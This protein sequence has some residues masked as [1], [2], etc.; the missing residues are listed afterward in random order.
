MIGSAIAKAAKKDVGDSIELNGVRFRIVGVYES[1]VGWEEMGGVISLRDAQTITGRPRKVTMISVKVKDPAQAPAIVD[2]I[3]RQ[4]PEVSAAL[5]ADF[6]EQ[7][8]DMKNS[9]GMMNGIS[10]LA[11]LVGG[12]GVMNTM[13]MAVLERTREIGVLRALGWRAQAVLGM[14][15]QEALVLGLLG[16]VAGIGVAFAMVFLM[17][18]SPDF[19]GMIEVIW[20]WDIFVRALVV[21]ALLGLV[22]GLYPAYRATRLQPVEALRYE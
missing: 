12:L 1:G 5:T 15:M 11:I 6:A 14:I 8:P 7:M 3:N 13:L 9:R 20:E 4:M 10:F 16:G 17:Q 19:G 18:A 22:G 2:E 21:A